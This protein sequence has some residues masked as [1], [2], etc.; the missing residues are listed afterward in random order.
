VEPGE[1]VRQADA[2]LYRAK[3]N[4]R[5]GAAEFTQTAGA[6]AEKAPHAAAQIGVPF[7]PIADFAT[8]SAPPNRLRA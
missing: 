7:G 4:G 8:A 2:A 3:A 6:A 5:G 1:L